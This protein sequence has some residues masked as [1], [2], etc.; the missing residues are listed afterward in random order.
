ME[1]IER[2][3]LD[4]KWSRGWN[5]SCKNFH[6]WR[7][8][9][10]KLTINELEH[11]VRHGETLAAEEFRRKTRAD[12]ASIPPVSKWESY[13][14]RNELSMYA[15]MRLSELEIDGVAGASLNSSLALRAFAAIYTLQMIEQLTHHLNQ[16]RYLNN[17]SPKLSLDYAPYTA[18]GVVIGCE[19]QAFDLARLQL[20]SYRKRLYEDAAYQYYP[21]Y[22]FVLRILA[23]FLKERPHVLS[24]EALF[25]PIY[26]TMFDLWRNPDA[27]ALVAVC[28]AACDYHL[29]PRIVGRQK[30]F[31]D[32]LGDWASWNRT[33]I[34][35]LLM[36]KLRQLL[37]LSNPDIDHPLMNTPLGVL[38]EEIPFD[39]LAK[40]PDD[41]I[42]RVR[43]RLIQDG[44][45]EQQIF[46]TCYQA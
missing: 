19:K 43:Q 7:D 28:L 12:N 27:N 22:H 42:Y 20:S 4:P 37:G 10:E 15:Q 44:Y 30:E 13:F 40:G 31:H 16:I 46:T 11:Y 5:A 3:G 6:K 32:F 26:R 1:I 29:Q 35:I 2:H 21:A 24:A 9:Y 23:D 18:L 17:F 39:D 25:D 8:I 45:D 36:F 38:P 41:L 34:E 14:L 33:P